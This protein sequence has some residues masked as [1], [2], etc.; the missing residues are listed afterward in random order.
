MASGLKGKDGEYQVNSLIYT[1]GDKADDILTSL[2]LSAEK[3]KVYEEVK[4]AFDGHF[5]GV[6]NV[7]YERA[8]FNKCCQ[9]AGESAEHFIMAVHKLAENCKYGDLHEEMIRDQIVVGIRDAG[10]SERLQ[11]N[12]KLN[13]A[14]AISQVRQQ[15]E[16][17]KQ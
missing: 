7:I 14:T 2:Q 10:L 9:E 11:L 1:M 5:V 6:H 4:T 13:L 8:K 16:V 15:E 17:K 12:P 3:Q